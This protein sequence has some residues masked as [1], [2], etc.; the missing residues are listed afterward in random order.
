MPIARTWLGRVPLEKADAYEV[1]LGRTGVPDHRATPGNQGVYVL[2]RRSED[3]VHFVLLTLWDSYAAIAAF[4]G[5][6]IER[7]RYYEE[8]ANFL[9]ELEP[10]VTHYEVRAAV[11]APPTAW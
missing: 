6:A 2:R 9:L 4:A 8:D 3:I 10:R 1:Y 5:D 11:F 7:A